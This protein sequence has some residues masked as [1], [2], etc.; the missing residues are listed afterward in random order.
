MAVPARGAPRAVRVTL[1]FSAA[2]FFIQM[3][4][5]APGDAA[6][7]LGFSS[8]DLGQRWWTVATFTLVHTSAW[9][10]IV[11]LGVLGVF[12]TYLERTWGTGEFIRYY[13]VCSLGAWIAHLAF[14]PAGTILAGSAAPA[15]GALLAF[16]A[17][18]GDGRHL[19]VG[20]ISLSTRSLAVLG[21]LAIVVAGTTTATP[22]ARMTYLAH[23]A[24]LVAGWGYLRTASSISLV[25][26]RDG[27]SPVPEESDDAPPRAVPRHHH[28]KERHEDDIVARSNAAVAREVAT[29]GVVA[30]Q[31]SDNPAGL[32]QVLDKISEQGLE[33]LSADERRLLDEMSRRLRDH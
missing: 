20:A 27:V 13:V 24:G 9:P 1:F 25:R 5:L 11:N 6:A 19:R 32:D 18:N 15:I 21:V 33:S 14:I 4:V 26:L 17:M 10:L 3:T 30:P 7:A 29:R 16:A 31:K 2:L 28:R 12:G 8:H 22:D 23:G